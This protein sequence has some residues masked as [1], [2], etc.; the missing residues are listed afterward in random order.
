MPS[1][2]QPAT[3]PV[4]RRLEVQQHT[5]LRALYE[6]FRV[7]SAKADRAREAERLAKQRFEDALL[8]APKPGEVDQTWIDAYVTSLH[9][10][11]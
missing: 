8:T 2:T 4:S 3:H 5:I 10:D 7:V 1:M 9:A 11:V 6:E